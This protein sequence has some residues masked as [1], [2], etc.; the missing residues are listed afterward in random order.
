MTTGHS[1]YTWLKPLDGEAE[2][3][4]W[5]VKFDTLLLSYGVERIIY[6]SGT[7]GSL[8]HEDLAGIFFE[9]AGTPRK[10]LVAQSALANLLAPPVQSLGR[11]KAPEGLAAYGFE[12]QGRTIIVAWAAEAGANN[13]SP[14]Q[15]GKDWKAVDLQAPVENRRRRD[16]PACL[17]RDRRSRPRSAV[18][19][20]WTK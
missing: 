15:A 10:M 13:H 12:S 2:A 4:E 8:N 18:A 16:G 6:H 17:L 7:I 3:A 20:G 11:L 5:Q 14:L 19:V 1:T 9:W